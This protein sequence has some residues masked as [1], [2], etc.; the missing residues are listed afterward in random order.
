MANSVDLDE[1]AHDEPPHQYLRCLQ[2]QLFSSLVLKELNSQNDLL[3]PNKQFKYGRNILLLL[4]LLLLLIKS[5]FLGFSLTVSVYFV[6]M[7]GEKLV[8]VLPNT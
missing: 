1:V 6:C 4:L 3:W 2:I 7:T 8:H 5:D